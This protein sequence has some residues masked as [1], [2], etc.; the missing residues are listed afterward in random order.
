[1][2]ELRSLGH[3]AELSAKYDPEFA[4][5]HWSADHPKQVTDALRLRFYYDSQVSCWYD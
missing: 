1:M 2:A 3:D 5:W 4:A